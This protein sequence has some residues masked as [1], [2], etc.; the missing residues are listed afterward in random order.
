MAV[1]QERGDVE[2]VALHADDRMLLQGLRSEKTITLSS[3]PM[4]NAAA[5]SGRGAIQFPGE[6]C[7]M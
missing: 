4:P 3:D 1:L 6:R 5:V 2:I 7:T